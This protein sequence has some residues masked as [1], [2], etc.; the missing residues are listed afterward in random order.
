[1]Q[2]SVAIQ[3]K[4]PVKYM[5]PFLFPWQ[6]Q[7]IQRY[8]SDYS[9]I[10]VIKFISFKNFREALQEEWKSSVSNRSKLNVSFESSDVSVKYPSALN[11][12]NISSN[13]S[14]Y[15]VSLILNN[16]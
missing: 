15:E 8:T 14:D 10:T 13:P 5:L 9:S 12:W 4:D 2:C 1:M 6:I 16:L 3:M 11:G 7:F